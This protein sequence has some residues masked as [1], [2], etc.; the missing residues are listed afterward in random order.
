M[1]SEACSSQR[2]QQS[3]R[4]GKGRASLLRE[5]L[6][7]T[8][9]GSDSTTAPGAGRQLGCSSNSEP[10]STDIKP[11]LPCISRLPRHIQSMASS[12]PIADFL[13]ISDTIAPKATDVSM[14]QPQQAS[15]VNLDCNGYIS[16]RPKNT[17]MTADKISG[18]TP[19]GHDVMASIFVSASSASGSER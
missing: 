4:V 3:P 11:V 5:K 15:D 14:L 13:N 1:S 8:D 17:C 6:M 16:S 19:A 18:A 12:A 2:W 10:E 9:Y 7:A